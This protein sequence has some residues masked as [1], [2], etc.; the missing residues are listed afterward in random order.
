[1]GSARS[2][3]CQFTVHTCTVK[4]ASVPL[5]GMHLT[6]SLL[7]TACIAEPSKAPGMVMYAAN[8]RLISHFI[9]V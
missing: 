1:M 5:S 2:N 3:S 6:L 7:A 4:P 9:R 8:I